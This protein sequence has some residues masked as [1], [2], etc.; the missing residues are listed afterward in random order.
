MRDFGQAVLGTVTVALLGA[1]HICASFSATAS[2]TNVH[3]PSGYDS[4]I[5]HGLT[6][7]CTRND[8]YAKVFGERCLQELA[9]K[10]V[11]GGNG[12]LYFKVNAAE[13]TN[14][15]KKIYSGVS[16]SQPPLDS[17]VV[18]IVS[19]GTPRVEAGYPDPL[20]KVNDE[21]QWTGTFQFLTTTYTTPGERPPQVCRVYC[22]GQWSNWQ[23]GHGGSIDATATVIQNQWEVSWSLSQSYITVLT[24]LLRAPA[25]SSPATREL[26]SKPFFLLPISRIDIPP[27]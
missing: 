6:W 19:P 5:S 9:G 1:A 3:L 20:T 16:V 14:L 8:S 23:Y 10:Y 21:W 18:E 2:E 7:L 24:V 13:W 11:I 27:F 17:F 25:P 26:F 22:R 15:Q 4:Y 12:H